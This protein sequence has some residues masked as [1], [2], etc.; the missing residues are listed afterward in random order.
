MRAL[1][2]QGPVQPHISKQE[3]TEGHHRTLRRGASLT[4]KSLG[5]SLFCGTLTAAPFTSERGL[6][7]SPTCLPH[8]QHPLLALFFAFHLHT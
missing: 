1:K 4:I 2:D 8:S 5:T 3:G 7:R 6:A